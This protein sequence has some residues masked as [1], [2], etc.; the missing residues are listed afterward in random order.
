MAHKPTSWVPMFIY[1]SFTERKHKTSFRV[2]LMS[3][4]RPKDYSLLHIKVAVN[5]RSG[6]DKI[7]LQNWY[8]FNTFF[9]KIV[10]FQVREVVVCA[11]IVDMT[12][13]S[14]ADEVGARHRKRCA[15][16]SECGGGCEGTAFCLLHEKPGFKSRLRT[17]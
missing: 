15:Q 13:L 3:W 16:S 17:N 8:G 10:I 7:K 1:E 6:F 12:A 9:L 11:T 5:H 2:L 4:N 14:H